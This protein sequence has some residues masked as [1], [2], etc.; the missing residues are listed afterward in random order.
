MIMIRPIPIRDLQDSWTLK[1]VTGTDAFGKP[2]Y[3]S[4][5]LTRVRAREKTD[6]NRSSFND[7]IMLNAKFMYDVRNSRPTGVTFDVDDVIVFSGK[8]YVIKHVN[9]PKEHDR[10]HHYTLGCV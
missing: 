7:N 4:T 9:A 3:S 10:V 2:T 8:D 1:K 6:L 5:S